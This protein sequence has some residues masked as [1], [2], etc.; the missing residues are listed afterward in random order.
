MDFFISVFESKLGKVMIEIYPRLAKVGMK[1]KK[2]CTIT[3]I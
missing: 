2:V 1:I 3:L